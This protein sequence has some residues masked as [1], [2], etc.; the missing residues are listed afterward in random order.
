MIFQMKVVLNRNT[1]ERQFLNN[2][3]IFLILGMGFMVKGDIVWK[4]GD[5]R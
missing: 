3:I 4:T 1:G 5:E 2:I